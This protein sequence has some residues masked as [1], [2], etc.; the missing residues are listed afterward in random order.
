M[1][2]SSGLFGWL[3]FILS[4]SRTA[5]SFELNIIPFFV[6]SAPFRRRILQSVGKIWQKFLYF[7]FRPLPVISPWQP[8]VSL[9][10]LNRRR[11]TC[12]RRS[13][14]EERKT[15]KTSWINFRRPDVACCMFLSFCF[16]CFRA[17]IWVKCVFKFSIKI[18]IEN[19][20]RIV[21]WVANEP[22][23]IIFYMIH[24]N[25]IAHIFETISVMYPRFVE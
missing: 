9:S 6:C 12:V 13:G 25:N 16:V 17:A 18:F 2:L 5:R 23:R 7:Q 21:F 8:Q 3:F 20:M 10:A 14:E 11:F 4:S 22:K 19:D 1:A 24:R 15:R